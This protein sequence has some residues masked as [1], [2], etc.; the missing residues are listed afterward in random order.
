[1]RALVVT[2]LA[3]LAACTGL[4]GPDPREADAAAA[5]PPPAVVQSAPLAPECLPRQAVSFDDEPARS[6]GDAL[7]EALAAIGAGRSSFG[8]APQHLAL[9]KLD[10]NDARMFVTTRAAI[11][12]PAQLP[13]Y[14]R[15][16]GAAFDEALASTTPVTRSILVASAMRE[17]PL[18]ACVDSSWDIDP[19]GE[20]PLAAALAIEAS[21]VEGVPLE[22]QRAL[23]P[24]VRALASAAAEIAAAR[25]AGGSAELLRPA[26]AVPSWLLGVRHFEWTE[27]VPMTF[28]RI[29]A[30]RIVRAGAS[31]AYAIERARLERFASLDLPAIDLETP[32]G[33]IVLRGVGNDAWDPSH[34]EAP[35]L[36]IDTGGD[37]VYRA[38]VAAAT[39][40][41][42]ISIMIDLGGR[43]TYGY[44]ES[45]SEEDDSRNSPLPAD[46]AGRAAGGRTLSTVGRQGSGTLGVGLLF[47]L[48][49]EAD[50][51][52]SLVASQGAGSHGVGVLYDDGGN[53]RYESEGFSQGAAAWGIGLLLDRGGDDRY[54]LHNSGQGFGFTGGVGGLIDGA[55]KDSYRAD[56]G[57][58][59]DGSL[60]YPSDQLP[61]FANHSFAQ[62]CGAGHR[63][64]WPDAGHP[65]PGGI[66]VLRDAS[67]DDRYA[68]GVFAQA[69]GFVEGLGLLLDGAG[70]DRYDGLYY[71]QGAA[72]HAAAALFLDASGNDRYNATY[73]IQGPALGIAHD[74][75]VAVHL[76]AGGDDTVR[77]S[78]GALGAGLANG[79]AL[80][81]NDA[82]ND[83]FEGD[84]AQSFGVG[85]TTDVSAERKGVPSVGIFVKAGGA[86]TYVVQGKA[87]SRAGR[88]WKHGAS[89]IEKGIGVDR[90]KGR[91][92]L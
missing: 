47:D 67:G 16:A 5:A 89:S 79:V 51:Y 30:S 61:G 65:F 9:S 52:R 2:A 41:R 49:G 43:D 85:T 88:S 45:A 21:K 72:A 27:E 1:M 44:D 15:R 13:A 82:G 7:D 48:G 24:I 62:G 8:L 86:S 54:T 38:P 63:P 68:A 66:G 55:G 81:V 84:G 26:T 57:P 14:G 56:P 23:V 11:H 10:T 53:D 42:P 78:W 29:D 73:P 32:L 20:A 31:V 6:R 25:A 58:S 3:V 4:P 39:L 34:A 83:R 40:A 12:R 37:D 50:T 35:T 80:F 46:A 28:E 36:F 69:C 18:D 71:V 74:L 59:F 90:P 70:N 22:L 76:D 92:Q 60:L 64:D 17:A 75:S 77:A 91:A 87:D 33:P 19:T